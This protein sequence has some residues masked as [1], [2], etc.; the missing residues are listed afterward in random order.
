MA[1]LTEMFGAAGEYLA[2]GYQRSYLN[3]TSCG[4]FSKKATDPYQE[5][6]KDLSQTI[7]G[8]QLQELLKALEPAAPQLRQEV[9]GIVGA[10]P[11]PFNCGKAEG[12]LDAS[13]RQSRGRWQSARAKFLSATKAKQ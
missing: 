10:E 9:Q 13:L 8:D 3:Q 1:S 11:T 7:R 4:K 5:S 6:L 12:V 2:A